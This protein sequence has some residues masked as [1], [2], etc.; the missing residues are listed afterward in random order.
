MISGT[1]SGLGFKE[2]NHAS[3]IAFFDRVMNRWSGNARDVMYLMLVK[4]WY[5]SGN[6]ICKISYNITKRGYWCKVS[7]CRKVR[8][9]L[10]GTLL[11][12]AFIIN[13]EEGRNLSPRS[14]KLHTMLS[15]DVAWTLITDTEGSL[16]KG[17]LDRSKSHLRKARFLG[18]FWFTFSYSEWNGNVIAN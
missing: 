14:W 3:T 9:R 12:Y 7:D 17:Q 11:V 16:K 18:L 13:L 15:Q 8:R 10:S 4:I 5:I 6:F 2:T 1:I